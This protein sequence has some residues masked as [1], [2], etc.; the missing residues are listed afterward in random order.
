MQAHELSNDI[1]KSLKTGNT[2]KVILPKMIGELYSVLTYTEMAVLIAIYEYA[3]TVTGSCWASQ[4]EIAD[5]L[6]IKRRETVTEAMEGLR[7]KG[8]IRT[9]K[10]KFINSKGQ[11]KVTSNE[12][13]IIPFEKYGDAEYLK[14]VDE[15]LDRDKFIT[16]QY[17]EENGKTIR[18]VVNTG[19]HTNCKPPKV[20][21]AYTEEKRQE[22]IAR[23]AEQTIKV[24]ET[25]V[26]KVFN[27]A[28]AD[29]ELTEMVKRAG[30][31][32]KEVQSIVYSFGHIAGQLNKL[33]QRSIEGMEQYYKE[34]G[35][36]NETEARNLFFKLNGI[37]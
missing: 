21:N 22:S 4:Q 37:G 12:T 33:T 31:T 7:A 14:Q 35:F 5:K 15:M 6:K 29:R 11:L 25:V 17:V 9:S 27:R 30:G 1:V 34:N 3:N 19:E 23:K 10:A 24:V 26:P 2:E 16:I 36:A 20:M 8:L 13:F 18:K 32:E 28:D